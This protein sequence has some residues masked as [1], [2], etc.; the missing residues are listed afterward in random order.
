MGLENGIC[1]RKSRALSLLAREKFEEKEKW[2][3][4]EFF[5]LEIRCEG[6]RIVYDHDHGALKVN[7]MQ[8]VE[9]ILFN[10]LSIFYPVSHDN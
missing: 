10:K 1:L 9:L 4:D 7:Q 5:A 3:L 6:H 2:D 8:P